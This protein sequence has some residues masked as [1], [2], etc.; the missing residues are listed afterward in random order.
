MKKVFKNCLPFFFVFCILCFANENSLVFAP[1][2]S[3]RAAA[4]EEFRR[5]VQSYYRG[6]FN[7]AVLLF[8][9]ALS[10]LP[11]EPVI[12]EW[13]GKAYYSSGIEGACIEQWSF[14]AGKGYGGLL[15]KNKIE[16]IK[17]RRSVIQD[18]TDNLKFAEAVTFNSEQNGLKLFMQ[19]VSAAALADG[20]FWMTSYGSNELLQ[21]DANG[22]I[23]RKTKG[24]IEGFDRP[25]DVIETAEGN[26][27]VSEFASDRISVISP[28]GAFIKYFGKSGIGKGGLMGPQYL[29]ED[30]YGNVYVSDFGNARISVFSPD[31]EPL[32]SFGQ[33]DGL[34]GGFIAPAGIAVV[35]GFVYAGDAIKGSISIFDTSG[36]Y[37]RDLLP[38]GTLKNIESVRAKGNQ[39]LVAA[40]AKAYLVDTSLASV[41]EVASLGKAPSK[42][43]G[44]VP[45]A[46]GNILLLD[47]KNETVEITSKIAELAGGLFVMIKRVYS[48]NFPH[49]ALEVS[50]E[51]RNREQIVGLNQFNFAVTENSRP[52]SGYKLE[53]AAYRNDS[54]DI[55]LVIERSPKSENEKKVLNHA[56]KEIA[57]A[58]DGKGSIRIFS[59]SEIPAAEGK[60]VPEDLT[61]TPPALKAKTSP[62]WKLDLGLRLASSDLINAQNKRALIFF[63][64]SELDSRN[65][66]RYS[67]N[68]LADYMSNN[69]IRFYSVNLK[70]GSLPDEISFLVNK[71]GGSAAYVYADAGL[72]P[73]VK[74]IIS[75]P[76]GIYRL[77]YDSAMS[78]DFGRKFLPVEVE[79]RLLNR[80]GRDETGYFAPLE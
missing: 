15:L 60:F 24:P 75:S 32:F 70:R 37:I 77:S 2:S 73:L 34:F 30:S 16:V 74:S 58:M 46:N 67:L 72:K 55:A 38:E 22:I 35:N 36:N 62:N 8:E 5:G 65:L 43:T 80:S 39:L 17:E 63:S 53:E 13:L 76:S 18:M 3:D 1:T 79:V 68:D 59:A 29:A 20:T 49:V 27:L 12:L 11:N 57:K 50:V 14:A 44:A 71:T 61:D 28:S 23:L 66:D 6:S 47:F 45:D 7:E 78:T 41:Y 51:T 52:V 25:F 64:F 69:G 48:D 42:V 31:G 4:S 54:C 26:L 33:K 40:G 9:K 56:I 10:F 19:P 21:F